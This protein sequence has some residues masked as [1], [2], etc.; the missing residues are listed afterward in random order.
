MV[1]KHVCIDSSAR[2]LGFGIV[3]VALLFLY[4]RATDGATG[5]QNMFPVPRDPSQGTHALEAPP[6]A[7]WHAHNLQTRQSASGGSWGGTQGTETAP[8][9]PTMRTTGDEEK[10]PDE[11][12]SG[13]PGSPSVPRGAPV[14]NTSKRRPQNAGDGLDVPQVLI[15]ASADTEAQSHGHA[16]GSGEPRG[17]P[18]GGVDGEPTTGALPYLREQDQRNDAISLGKSG[19]GMVTKEAPPSGAAEDCR[20]SNH[21]G[22]TKRRVASEGSCENTP[23]IDWDW[24]LSN[25]SLVYGMH[26]CQVYR[27][28][29]LD[30]S[31][32]VMYDEQYLPKNGS[33]PDLPVFGPLPP[34]A[35][36]SP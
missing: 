36:V 11:T 24:L 20:Q 15:K 29:C 23:H 8:T 5:T 17:S 35:V 27:L 2:G 9:G 34:H 14:E 12:A 3:S 30:Q 7:A 18:Q 26:G 33:G 13:P 4:S 21:S 19:A 32:F 6:A 28:V 31:A 22:F 16:G 10:H 25:D 1:V